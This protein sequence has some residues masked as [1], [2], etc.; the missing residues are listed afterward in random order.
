MRKRLPNQAARSI[1]EA[2]QGNADVQVNDNSFEKNQTEEELNS[3]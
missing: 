1:T 2:N 3:C